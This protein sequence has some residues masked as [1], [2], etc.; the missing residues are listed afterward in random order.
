MALQTRLAGE[1]DADAL[2]GPGDDRFAVLARAGINFRDDVDDILMALHVEDDEPYWS[3]ALLGDLS[4]DVLPALITD[5]FDV[6]RQD[7]GTVYFTWLD[8]DTC[9]KSELHAARIADDF[10]LIAPA[11]RVDDLDNRIRAGNP[12]NVAGFTEWLRQS[13]EQLL[14]VGVFTPES[15]GQAANGMA[16]MMLSAAGQ[17]A[18]PAESLYLGIKPSLAPPGAQF[19][20]SVVSDDAAFLDQAHTAASGWLVTAK[21]GAVADA[22]DLVPIYERISVEREGRKFAA[23]VQLDTDIGSEVEKLASALFRNAFSG[24]MAS[25]SASPGEEQLEESPMQFANASTAQICGPMTRLVTHLLNRNGNR[26]RSRFPFPTYS[27]ARTVSC[28]SS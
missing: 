24:G 7:G 4:A 14:T 5:Q 11:S 8:E 6:E 19:N 15:V 16:R 26:D 21:E 23:G 18:S 12:S 22:P 25:I 1:P 17:A 13:E 3:M 10:V 20:V 28:S 9:E 27:W 2:I